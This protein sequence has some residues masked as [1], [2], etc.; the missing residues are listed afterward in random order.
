MHIFET[1][2]DGL[3][4]CAS[5]Y[6]C[7][8]R[9]SSSISPIASEAEYEDESEEKEGSSQIALESSRYLA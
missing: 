7:I 4:H 8:L 2:K 1:P 5:A 6:L 9:A 3:L